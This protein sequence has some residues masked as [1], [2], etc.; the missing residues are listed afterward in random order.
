MQTTGA[1]LR[2]AFVIVRIKTIDIAAQEETSARQ[3]Q[4]ERA[5]KSRTDGEASERDREETIIRIC[6]R[7]LNSKDDHANVIASF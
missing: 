1:K 2:Y 4:E 5:G 6:M 7:R 3:F